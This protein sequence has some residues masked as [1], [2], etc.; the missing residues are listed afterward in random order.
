MRAYKSYCKINGERE[1]L[2][3]EWMTQENVNQHLIF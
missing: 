1:K 2:K 3:L